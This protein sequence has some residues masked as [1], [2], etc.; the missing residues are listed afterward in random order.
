MSPHRIST[1]LGLLAMLLTAP[2]ALAQAQSTLPP[3][4][5]PPSAHAS[6]QPA[7]ASGATANGA[8]TNGATLDPEAPSAFPSS[9]TRVG[10]HIGLMVPLLDLDTGRQHFG[11]VVAAD[12]I[13]LSL[14]SGITVKLSE[15]VAF[16]F[17]TIVGNQLKPKGGTDLTIDPGLLLAVGP[18][19]VGARI[20]V[21]PIAPANIGGIL[22][23][24]KSFPISRLLSF[25]VELDFPVTSVQDDG[26]HFDVVLHTGMSF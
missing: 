19:I 12:F 23:V 8:T 17:E 10:G 15:S 24:N 22:L 18:V 3:P 26:F 2:T 1:I 13:V 5:P 14:A 11:Q 4:T 9:P 25:F 20:A 16:D 21:K 7:T 6:T